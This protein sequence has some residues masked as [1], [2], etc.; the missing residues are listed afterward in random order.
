MFERI[1]F[2]TTDKKNSDKPIDVGLL[3]ESMLFYK[4]TTVISNGPNIL[5]QLI[6]VLGFE[7][8]NELLERGILEI[9]YTETNTGIY[10]D[11]AANGSQVHDAII[12]S[13]P[14][15]TFPFEI[16]KA[17]IEISGKEGKGRRNA[18]RLSRRIRVANHEDTLASSA[19]TLLLDNEFLSKAVP[20]LMREWVPE[21]NLSG[22][23]FRSEKSEKGIVVSTN[24]NFD[25]LNSF[26]HLRIPASHSSLS[27]AFILTNLYDIETDL[28]YA[29]RNLSEISSSNVESKL[30]DLRLIHLAE[31]CSKSTS[32]KDSFQELVFNGQKTVREAYNSGKIDLQAILRAI[33]GADKFKDW[34]NK[35]IIDAQLLK[36]YFREVTKDSVIDKLPSKSIRW[37]V[38]TGAGIIGDLL[39]TGG[40]GTAVGVSLSVLDGFFLDKLIK[41]WKPNQFVEGHLR[42]LIKET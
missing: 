22:L 17:C 10:T 6:R 39:L 38:F 3:L 13:S 20:Q 19:R 14:Q 2:R 37:S 11:T 27:T 5:K 31:R 18:T 36:E 24:L 28:Y 41:G 25:L 1:T 34:L 12:F 42:K 8:L 23:V 21:V 33:Y 32:E 7:V 4:K 26:Y 15:H 30:I 16:R 9:I 29:S 40:I 35:Q